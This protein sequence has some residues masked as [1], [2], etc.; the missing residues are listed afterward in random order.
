MSVSGDP[1]LVLV[2]LSAQ[3]F[4]RGF[5]PQLFGTLPLTLYVWIFVQQLLEGLKLVGEA[6]LKS[7]LYI[8]AYQQPDI[9]FL[10]RGR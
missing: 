5:N 8:L 9:V 1:L 4:I 10:A 3:K 6:A 7:F 2:L